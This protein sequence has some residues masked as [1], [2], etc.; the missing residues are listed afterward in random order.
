[1]FE[2]LTVYFTR[3]HASVQ[4][5]S[6]GARREVSADTMIKVLGSMMEDDRALL[7]RFCQ[8]VVECSAGDCKRLRDW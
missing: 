5:N 8:A 2:R 6:D 3:G 4:V 7:V 1:M